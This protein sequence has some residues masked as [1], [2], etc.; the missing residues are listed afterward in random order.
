MFAYLIKNFLIILVLF[1]VNSCKLE[2]N[3]SINSENP[4]YDNL[5]KTFARSKPGEEI[6]L[7]VE[8][9]SSVINLSLITGQAD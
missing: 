5:Y 2:S 7:Q 3:N 4:S 8:R 1:I 6:L 9:G